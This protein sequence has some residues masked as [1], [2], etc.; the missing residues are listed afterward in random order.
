MRPACSCTAVTARRIASLVAGACSGGSMRWPPAAETASRI[1][2]NTENGSSSG[3][4]PTALLRWM[5]SSTFCAVEQPH[6]EDRRAVV[7]GRDLVGA[8]RVRRQ[9]LAGLRMPDQL[10]HRQPAHALDEGAFDLADV[11]RRVQR[12]AGVVQHVGAQQLPFAGERVDDHLAD[13]G[14]VGEVVERAGPVIVSRSQLQ[15]GRGVEA[16]ATRAAR[17]PCRPARPARRRRCVVP[18]TSTTSLAKRTSAASPP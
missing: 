3:G 17:A 8:R 11:D 9:Q 13:R 7:G 2:K 1:A 4:S 18:S 15:A 16:V 12:L 5:L 10:F 14:A 6:V